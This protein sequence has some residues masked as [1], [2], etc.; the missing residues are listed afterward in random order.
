MAYPNDF[1]ETLVAA[2]SQA[3]ASLQLPNSF[4]GCVYTQYTPNYTAAIGQTL[5]INVPSVNVSNASDL[6][7]S[8]I[9]G[10]SPG[11]TSVSLT[12]NH[13]YSSN[14]KISTYE[15]S[16]SANELSQVYLQPVIEEV[17]RKLDQ[18]MAADI[19]SANFD[20]YSS[21]TAGADILTRANIATGWANLR[22]AG[23]PLGNPADNKLVVHS[24]VYGNMMAASEFNAE[25]TVGIRA[26][27]IAQRRAQILDQFGFEL[28][29]DPYVPLPG[30]GTYAALMMHRFAY[31]L[32]TV[33]QPLVRTGNL[34]QTVVFPRPNVPVVIETWQEPKDQARYIHAFVIC[35][36]GVTRADMAQFLVTT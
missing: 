11:D 22:A 28:V 10:V 8:G 36:H 27:E 21:I 6:G 32:R 26:A 3:T 29:D 23:V 12:I 34:M 4:I 30:A 15:A 2:S 19:T 7:N 33:T 5:K 18:A 25:A 35:G 17:L 31:G 20:S 16:L 14:R 9:T 24:T 1:Y 13:K